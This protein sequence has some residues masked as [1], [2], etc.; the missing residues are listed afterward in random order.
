MLHVDQQIWI[1]ERALGIA[2]EILLLPG[3]S[4]F[5]GRTKMSA[6][7]SGGKDHQMQ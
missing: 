2:M 4:S 1:D 3:N 7:L 6:K 5:V